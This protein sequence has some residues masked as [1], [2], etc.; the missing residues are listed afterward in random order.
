MRHSCC[1]CSRLRTNPPRHILRHTHHF[2]APARHTLSHTL[3]RSTLNHQAKCARHAFF[4]FARPRAKPLK[5]HTLNAPVCAFPHYQPR[6]KSAHPPRVFCVLRPFVRCFCAYSR[7]NPPRILRVSL[8][9]MPHSQLY[10]PHFFV[11]PL[12]TANPPRYILSYTH[13]ALNALARTHF[14]SAH[15]LH[16]HP[17][18]FTPRMPRVFC[19]FYFFYLNSARIL[20]K[21]F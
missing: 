5:R 3:L 20:K 14:F 1:F 13:R 21:I 12:A 2:F 10:E 15:P 19:E 8:S 4:L 16:S 18:A 6:A 17:R 11:C 9:A 7:T